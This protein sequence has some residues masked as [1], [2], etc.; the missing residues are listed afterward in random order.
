[1]LDR[2]D[3]APIYHVDAALRTPDEATFAA[4]QYRA[5]L[6]ETVSAVPESR[7]PLGLPDIH[8]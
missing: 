1:M 3:E 7:A 4:F 6:F 5:N 2:L 8:R